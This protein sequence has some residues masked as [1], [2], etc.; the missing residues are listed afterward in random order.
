MFR[1][2]VRS[3][4]RYR[5]LVLAAAIGLMAWGS[6]QMRDMRVV[7]SAFWISIGVRAGTGPSHVGA[8]DYSRCA[9]R[10]GCEA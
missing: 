3:S 5:T 6:T 4:L 2:I 1:W 9:A 8:H 7:T 10:R